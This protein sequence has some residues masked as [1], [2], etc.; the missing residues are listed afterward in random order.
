[1]TSINFIVLPRLPDASTRYGLN[2]DL[3]KESVRLGHS[4]GE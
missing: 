3:T 4:Y 2:V 1:M